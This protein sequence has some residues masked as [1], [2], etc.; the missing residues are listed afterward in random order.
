MKKILPILLVAL[1]AGT[2]AIARVAQPAAN[3]QVVVKTGKMVVDSE[4]SRLAP[5]LRVAADGS[6]QI[7]FQG[8]IVTIPV[9]TLSVVDGKLTTSLKKA[10]VLAMR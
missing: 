3:E 10:E 8:K 4:G 2:P 9:S 1:V 5:V 6:A 7:I